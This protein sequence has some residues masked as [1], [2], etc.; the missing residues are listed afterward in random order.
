MPPSEDF[1]A[2]VLDVIMSSALEAYGHRSKAQPDWFRDNVDL[3]PTVAAKISNRFFAWVRLSTRA[4]RLLRKCREH[5][6]ICVL[7]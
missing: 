6:T 2:T 7:K 4:S 3:L 1:R 5:D